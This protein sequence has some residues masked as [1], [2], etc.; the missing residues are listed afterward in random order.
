M[1]TALV[2]ITIRKHKEIIRPILY[3]Y[4]VMNYFIAHTEITVKPS[5]V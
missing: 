3:G 2:L 4:L 1:R 5:N